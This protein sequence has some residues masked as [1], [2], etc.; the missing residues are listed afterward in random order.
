MG[1]SPRTRL[2]PIF[3]MGCFPGRFQ[4]GKGPLRHSGTRPIKVRKKKRPFRERKRPHLGSQHPSPTILRENGCRK[5][6]CNK[7]GLKGR[8]AA[9]PRN[10]PKSAFFAL[11][12]PF[13]PFSGGCE[14]L[15]GNPE[16]GGKRPFSSNILRFAEN[17]IS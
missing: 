6:G 2:M 8:L 5:W 10:R 15:L 12:L 17:P 7:W 14:E 11:F 13:S 4:Q 3:L 9:L 16:N 1:W